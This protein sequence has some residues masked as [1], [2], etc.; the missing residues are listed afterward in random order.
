[1]NQ[2]RPVVVLR[3]CGIWQKL[4]EDRSAN[5][6]TMFETQVESVRKMD[7]NQDESC[8]DLRMRSDVIL[9]STESGIVVPTETTQQATSDDQLLALWLHGRPEYHPAGVPG[10]NGSVHGIC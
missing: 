3:L 6:R 2:L 10:R 7:E 8:A 9:H 1:M 4:A 5:V